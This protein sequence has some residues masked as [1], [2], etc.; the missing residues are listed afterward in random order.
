MEEG[1]ERVR[2]LEKR[3]RKTDVKKVENSQG[4]IPGDGG[5]K[6]K[7]ED[8]GRVKEERYEKNG[9]ESVV[10]QKEGSFIFLILIVVYLV[11]DGVLDQ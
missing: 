5:Y 1:E 9:K 3:D 2:E 10:L 11:L 4:A 7:V 8:R 6:K